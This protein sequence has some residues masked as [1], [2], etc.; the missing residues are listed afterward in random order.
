MHSLFDATHVV[1]RKSFEVL[2]SSIFGY[3]PRSA[4][5]ARVISIERRRGKLAHPRMLR[6][7]LL[8]FVPHP[9]TPSRPLSCSAYGIFGHRADCQ[10]LSYNAA[11]MERVSCH[12]GEGRTVPRPCQN[13]GIARIDIGAEG[14]LRSNIFEPIRTSN[15]F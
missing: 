12:S 11:E 13:A 1:G 7:S 4:I 14:C 8:G 15:S 5:S 10:L 6:Q 3:L 9:A 2:L